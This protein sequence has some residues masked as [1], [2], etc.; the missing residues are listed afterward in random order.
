M[1]PV[2]R[3]GQ[4]QLQPHSLSVARRVVPQFIHH[5]GAIM[6]HN[7]SAARV[8]IQPAIRTVIGDCLPVAG[9]VFAGDDVGIEETHGHAATGTDP[10][11]PRQ[12]QIG[13][14]PRGLE[15]ATTRDGHVFP[16]GDTGNANVTEFD[17][18]AK[19][20]IAI[21]AA[22]KFIAAGSRLHG[23]AA[24]FTVTDIPDA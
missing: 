4:A 18:V 20:A 23:T 9:R 13:L 19:A 6:T 11:A 22:A 21:D 12:P 24:H 2:V 5:R 10:E 14:V 1:G 3:R 8:I 17:M 16:A 7:L 15:P